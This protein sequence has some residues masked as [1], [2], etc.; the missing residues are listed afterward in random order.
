LHY[1]SDAYKIDYS[2]LATNFEDF[3][4]EEKDN[5]SY[6]TLYDDYKTYL[7]Q[8]ESVLENEF[9]K[10]N[11]FQTSIRAFKCRGV[12]SSEEEANFHAKIIREYDPNFDVLVG[13]V[14][15]WLP[16]D[17]ESYKTSKVE[18]LEE[19]LNQLMHE[20][21]K[22]EEYAKNAFDKRIE[23]AKKKAI[24]DNKLNAEKYGNKITQDLDESNNLIGVK[25]TQEK[26][27][28]TNPNVSEK[29]IVDELFE[30]ENI[31]LKKK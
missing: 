15:L 6:D 5:I 11:K 29:E 22:N 12:Y 2:G 16:W 24:N 31:V 25:N 17:P 23:D 19:E 28:T 13:P 18:Y 7:D 9:N 10:K 3:I 14:G 8:N 27:L 30:G 20:K 4:K 26:N 21:I 1:I